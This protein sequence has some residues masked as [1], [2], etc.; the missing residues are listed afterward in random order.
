MTDTAIPLSW[1]TT[2]SGTGRMLESVLVANRGEIA[3]RVIRTCRRLGVRSIAV[4]S[5]A[6]AGAPHVRLAD[7]AIRLGAAPA[8]ESYLSVERVLEAARRAGAQAIHPGYGFLSENAAFAQSCADAGL[9]F[10]GPSAAAM[11]AL[12]D[13]VRAKQA[14]LAAGV[15]V[16]PGLQEPGL[17][18]AQIVAFVDAGEVLPLMVKAAAGGGGRG[19]RVVKERGEL[20]EALAAARREAL[21]GFADD[22][23]L[24]ERYVPRARHVE[25]QV[26]ADA[27]GNVVHLGERECSL[28]RRHQ[29]VVEESPSPVI[30]DATRAALGSCAAQLFREVGYVGAGTCE[31]LVPYDDP[32]EFFFLEVNA[33]LQVEHPV[34]ECVTGI[35]LVELQLR[36]AAGDPLGFAQ[37][38]VRLEGHAVE[39]RVC[40]EDPAAGFLPATGTLLLY[41]EPELPGVR[42]DSGVQTGSVIGSSYDSLIAK[43]IV[44]GPDREAALSMLSRALTQFRALG[45]VTNAGF[46]KRLV[47]APQV[48][49]GDMDTG[50]IERGVAPVGPQAAAVEAA[51]QAVVDHEARTLR[52]SAGEDPWDALVGFRLEGPAPLG[53]RLRTSGAAEP[54]T[55]TA[56][57]QPSTYPAYAHAAD[58][59]V[60]W[61]ACGA[62]A[63]RFEIVEP[64][65]LGPDAAAEGALEAPMPGTV[66]S[67]RVA[68]GQTVEEGAVLVVLESMKME[69][70]LAA[71]G[72]AIVSAVHVTEGQSVK[73]GQAVV[74]LEAAS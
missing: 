8:A 41:R 4:Y 43:I 56:A 70:T 34:T 36:I 48:R 63:F 47:D 49:A 50:L 25:V 62:D 35:D 59:T 39:V 33:R 11:E 21:A 19:M 54:L 58:G 52:E 68:V 38:D 9:I 28:Q 30:D 6:D 7:E 1:A 42:T 31:F 32:E 27:H 57:E 5:D 29:K 15:P 46:L 73:Q 44:H 64:T 67:V 71:P 37:E 40:A 65:V 14:A 66:L 51:A 2:G 23:L 72:A 45:V 16:L 61:A 10:I 18:D 3:C 69:L 20:V 13:K 55:V 22:T 74:E 17:T 53:L 60:R 26:V 12:G 24:V